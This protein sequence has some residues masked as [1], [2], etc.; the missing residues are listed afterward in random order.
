MQPKGTRRQP[1][2]VNALLT[3]TLSAA[4]NRATTGSYDCFALLLEGARV[5]GRTS[6]IMVGMDPR[7]TD[8]HPRMAGCLCH[9]P[10]MVLHPGRSYADRLISYMV[11]PVLKLN[12]QD[13]QS[14]R[15]W[16]STA[17]LTEVSRSASL[18]AEQSQTSKS[19]HVSLGFNMQ[20][21][22]EQ[23]NRF[24]FIPREDLRF[25]TPRAQREKH[26]RRLD[27]EIAYSGHRDPTLLSSTLFRGGNLRLACRKRLP[28]P[29]D[30]SFAGD[31]HGSRFI[32]AGRH[33][34]A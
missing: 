28:G 24:A 29:I 12:P 20:K 33:L 23:H 10:I 2:D 22:I 1:Q 19:R 16:N 13:E 3:Q 21:K 27:P 30:G 31:E 8:V 18:G 26:P 5:P 32:G 25:S 15:G 4:F 9:P 6:E 17:Q 11:S 34:E 14:Q 7:E